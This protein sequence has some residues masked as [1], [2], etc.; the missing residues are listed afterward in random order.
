MRMPTLRLLVV[1]AL[2]LAPRIAADREGDAGGSGRPIVVHAQPM[3][4]GVSGDRIGGDD[5]IGRLRYRA[6]LHLT[7]ASEDF[8]GFSGLS[9]AGRHLTAVSDQG[10]WLTAALELDQHGTVKGLQAARMGRLCD[11]DGA[12]VAWERRDAEEVQHLPGHGYLVSFERHHRIVLYAES[13]NGATYPQP[14]AGATRPSRASG[15]IAFDGVPQP[16][17]FPPGI[18]ATR[19]N[20]GMEAVAL[21][22]DGRLLTFAEDLRTIDD[23]I[24][25]WIGR[26]DAGD[27]RHL[28]L[29]GLGDFLPTGAAVLPGGDLLLLVRNYSRETGNLIRLLLFEAASL[30]P[31]ARLRPVELARI[32]P[33]ATIDNMESVAVGTGPGG[34]T[35]VYLLSDNNY[36]DDQRTLLM[37]FEL[38]D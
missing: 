36:N 16:F 24:I 18:V 4:R 35:L 6:V 28:T 19:R 1:F 11:D 5:R 3:P 7:S 13:E 22:P 30:T 21:L 26:P 15:A 31:G 8:G 38:L 17:P 14:A 25:G 37:Q 10:H 32:E 2:L 34:E 27:W 29:P 12:P 20:K 33:P 23:D 9:I